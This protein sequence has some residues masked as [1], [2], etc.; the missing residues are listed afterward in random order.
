MSLMKLSNV[1]FTF[2]ERFFS[3]LVGDFV[4]NFPAIICIF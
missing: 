3:E 4:F 2:V 1:S